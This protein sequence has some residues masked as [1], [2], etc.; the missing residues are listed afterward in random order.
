MD[1]KIVSIPT[2]LGAGAKGKADLGFQTNREY[3][4]ALLTGF[5]ILATLF[6]L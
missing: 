6:Y 4:Q 1:D 2:P 3:S 5:G